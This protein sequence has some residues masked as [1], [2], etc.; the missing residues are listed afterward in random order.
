MNP[1]SLRTAC[2]QGFERL[3]ALTGTLAA[4]VEPAP[5]IAELIEQVAELRDL[6]DAALT[7]DDEDHVTHPTAEERTALAAARGE[8]P[9]N[10]P[11]CP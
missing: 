4:L 2:E 6:F 9:W 10:A 8:Y 3:D 1:P 7:A 11:R 5:W